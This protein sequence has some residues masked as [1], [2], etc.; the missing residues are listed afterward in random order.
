MKKK[1]LFLILFIILVILIIVFTLSRKKENN[2]P[3]NTS[4]EVNSI[5]NSD[6]ISQTV[7][8]QSTHEN[9]IEK[10]GL[11]AKNI[12]IVQNSSDLQVNTT[13]KNNSNEK[14]EGFF[15]TINLLDENGNII[16]TLSENC[17]K[18]LEANEEYT[19]SNSVVG[20]ENK[21]SF[22]KAEITALEKGIFAKNIENAFDEMEEK[23]TSS[24]E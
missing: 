16:T 1:Y 7:N 14:I 5:D 12:E 20:I 8:I 15:I 11:E 2:I 18:T 24:M 10:D 13:L 17:E 21:P 6:V 19:I 22:T 4:N 3:N 9:P 23:A